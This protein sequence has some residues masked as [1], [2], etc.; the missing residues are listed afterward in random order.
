MCSDLKANSAL[1]KQAQRVVYIF[2]H[3]NPNLI[4]D[5]LTFFQILSVMS[6]LFRKQAISIHMEQTVSVTLSQ[7][8]TP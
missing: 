7:S 8:N 6:T 3:F 2:V 1:V 5:G 4:C